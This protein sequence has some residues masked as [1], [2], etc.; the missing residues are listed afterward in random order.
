M[1]NQRRSATFNKRFLSP[2]GK[3]TPDHQHLK[4]NRFKS[5]LVTINSDLSASF[6]RSVSLFSDSDYDS[7]EDDQHAKEPTTQTASSFPPS[8]VSS[9][10]NLG[11]NLGE[12]IDGCFNPAF[13]QQDQHDELKTLREKNFYLKQKL[14]ASNI[15]QQQMLHTSITGPSA[16]SSAADFYKKQHDTIQNQLVMMTNFASNLENKSSNA[17]KSNQHQQDVIQNLKNTAS[18]YEKKLSEVTKSNKEEIQLY[19]K[20][21]DQLTKDLKKSRSDHRF[22]LEKSERTIE[23]LKSDLEVF[24][25]GNERLVE[26]ANTQIQINNLLNNEVQALRNSFYHERAMKLQLLKDI[27][28]LRADLYEAENNNLILNNQN[29]NM[30]QQDENI[31]SNVLSHQQMSVFADAQSVK[32]ALMKPLSTRKYCTHNQLARRILGEA[33]AT[34]PSVSFEYNAQ[35][36]SFARAQLLAEAGLLDNKMVDKVAESSPGEGVMR[37]IMNDI[38]TDVLFLIHKNIF[39]DNLKPDGQYPNVYISA[40]KGTDGSFVKILSWFDRTKNR[41][42]QKILDVDATYGTSEQTAHAM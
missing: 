34:H 15:H 24:R 7:D 5:P 13:E 11:C 32:E 8:W 17:I 9:I 12:V 28:I 42:E 20:R 21:F 22:G 40:D 23:R 10:R 31:R 18:K 19:L 6:N 2:S 29:H 4:K 14:N 39:Y 26:N 33:V 30:L 37:K 1:S 35:I 41:V 16:I 27:E 25:A 3:Q 38:A 36:T